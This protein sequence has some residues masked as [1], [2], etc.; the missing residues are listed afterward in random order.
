M[1][2]ASIFNN[3]V[4]LL[5]GMRANAVTI[6][7]NTINGARKYRIFSL[8]FGAKSSLINSLRAFATGFKIF[9]FLG[10]LLPYLCSNR[11]IMR[12]LDMLQLKLQV[13]Y[14]LL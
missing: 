14:L 4:P 11:L 9:V 10:F 3:G 5:S 13:L 2:D 12:F 1:A 8:D 6:G 7:Q